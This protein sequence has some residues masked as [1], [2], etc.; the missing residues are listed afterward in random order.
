M[1]ANLYIITHARTQ[2]STLANIYLR[3]GGGNIVEVVFYLFSR[4][5]IRVAIYL[6]N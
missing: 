1:H 4:F 5:L 6:F 2:A 3:Q